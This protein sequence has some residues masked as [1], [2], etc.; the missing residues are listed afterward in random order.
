MIQE[1]NLNTILKTKLK[2]MNEL[3]TFQV[4]PEKWDKFKKKC[5]KMNSDAS[6]ELRKFI[7]EQI[8]K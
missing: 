5:K 8:K 7:D 3:R 4:D 6:K 2:K 1:K